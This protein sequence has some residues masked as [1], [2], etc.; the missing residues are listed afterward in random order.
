MIMEKSSTRLVV[1]RLAMVVLVFS[2]FL[3]VGACSSI[4]GDDDPWSTQYVGPP[5]DVWDAIHMVLFD[6]DYE[7]DEENRNDGKIRATREASDSRKGAVLHIDQIMRGE[8]VSVYV[9]VAEPD[10]AP[11]MDRDQQGVMAAEF[12]TPIKGILYP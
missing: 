8:I 2:A 4:S 12:L 5:N 6:L 1:Q 10:G 7:V 3:F 11:I 9:R